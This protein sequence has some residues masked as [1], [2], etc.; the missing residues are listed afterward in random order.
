MMLWLLSLAHAGELGFGFVPS[1]GPGEKPGLLVTPPRPVERMI[2][3]CVVGGRT[4]SWDKR[5]LPAGKMQRYEWPRDESQTHADCEVQVV[6]EDGSAEMANLPIDWSYGAALKVDLSR[7]EADL[8]KHT[9]SV[10]VTAWVDRAEVVAFGAR[11]VLLGKD[12]I[13]IQ[14]GPGRIQVPWVGD[15]AKVVLLDVTLHGERAWSGFTFSPWFLDV[16]HEDVHFG[17]DS[18]VIESTEEHKL[19]RTLTDLNDVLEQYGEIV[20]VQLFIGGCTD[21]VGDRASNK[22]LSRRR[23]RAIAR[24]LRGHGYSGPIFY[25]GFGEDWLAVGTG[26]SVNEQANRRAVY[27]VGASAPPRGSGVP[28]TNW[29]Q[30]P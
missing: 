19:E 9:V 3:D 7:A 21:T 10:D 5:G 12:V 11:R 28:A 30:I 2:V 1:P 16:P 25:S 14:A 8:E 22:N 27:M 6:F 26:D 20:P 23:A 18:D 17:T 4:F 29:T 24:W 15:P 13:P